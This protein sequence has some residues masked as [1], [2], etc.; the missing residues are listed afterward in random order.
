MVTVKNYVKRTNKNDD[1]FFI[2][3][4]QGEVEMIKSLKSERFYAHARKAFITTTV[5]ELT[6][7]SLIGTKFPGSIKKV[8]SEPY[9]YQIPGTNDS[10]TLNHTYQYIPDGLNVEETIFEGQVL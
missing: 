3:E 9:N 10:I 6:C 5:D 1:A 7:K 8:E 4:L 2:L